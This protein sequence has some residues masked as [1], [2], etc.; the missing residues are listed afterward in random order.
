[1]HIYSTY[2]G[3]ST[4]NSFVASKYAP[5]MKVLM[6]KINTLVLHD[7]NNHVIED[8]RKSEVQKVDACWNQKNAHPTSEFV[9]MVLNGSHALLYLDSSLT[10]VVRQTKYGFKNSISGHLCFCWI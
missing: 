3:L 6:Q 8:K 10:T 1:M 4:S 7:E 2:S 5:L 9:I